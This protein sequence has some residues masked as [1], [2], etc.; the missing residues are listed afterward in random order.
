MTFWVCRLVVVSGLNRIRPIS[1]P[2]FWK[3]EVWV[4]T[5]I[6]VFIWY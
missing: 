5:K 1:S 6:F 3:N 2:P 4:A